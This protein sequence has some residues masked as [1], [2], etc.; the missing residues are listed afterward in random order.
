MDDSVSFKYVITNQSSLN[1]IAQS[2]SSMLFKKGE[3]SWFPQFQ[4]SEC[5]NNVTFYFSK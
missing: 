3:V 1:Y 2:K 4:S 5:F